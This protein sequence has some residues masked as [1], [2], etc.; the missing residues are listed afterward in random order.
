MRPQLHREFSH[1]MAQMRR[2]GTTAVNQRLALV[3]TSLYEYKVLML[4]V[5]EPEVTQHEVVFDCAMDKAAV[6]RLIRTFTEQGLVTVR[7]HPDDKRQRLLKIT[8]KG[9]AKEAMLA[10]IVDDALAPFMVG[11]SDDEGQE[12]LRLMRKAYNGC[13]QASRE[14]AVLE[15]RGAGTSTYPRSLAPQS[16]GRAAPDDQSAAKKLAKRR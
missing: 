3:G 7:V 10:P 8:P 1:L 12:L 15:G 6:S 2:L 13:L 4:L 16:E 5:N 14:Q 9:R 11:L